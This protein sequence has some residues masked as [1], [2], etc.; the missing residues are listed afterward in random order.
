MIFRAERAIGVDGAVDWV[1]VDAETYDLHVEATAFLVG[2]RGRDRSPNTIRAYAS[3]VAAEPQLAEIAERWASWDTAHQKYMQSERRLA[4]VQLTAAMRT[5]LTTGLDESLPGVQSFAVRSSAEG[6]DGARR[7]FA[8]LYDSKLRVPGPGMDLEE[9]IVAVWRSWFSLSAIIHRAESSQDEDAWQPPALAVV[10]QR[11]INAE[12]AGVAA[13]SQDSVE[14]EWVEGTG[15]RLVDGSAD[16]A[17]RLVTT[18]VQNPTGRVERAAAAAW[19]LRGQLRVGDLDVEW[20]ADRGRVWVV[21]AR[22]LTAQ[23]PV[24]PGLSWVSSSTEPV[25][26]TTALYA[27]TAPREVLP[28]GP[29][30]E[31]ID[32]YR[33]KR[34][35]CTSSGRNTAVSWG[36]RWSCIST[37][38]AWPDHGGRT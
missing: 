5:A 25:L 10:V 8:G 28:L 27:D 21:Q 38:R 2:L 23:V 9:A 15:E 31:L 20:A 12:V 32:H 14:M 3:R 1:V 18:P 4:G 17:R 35:P 37:P 13:V 26:R 7:S 36:R 30:A 6:E 22:P 11:M 33:T 34:R 19:A 29:V 16:P 24:N